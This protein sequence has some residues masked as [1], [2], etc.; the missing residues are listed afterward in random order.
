MR[1]KKKIRITI[2]SLC[3]WGFLASSITA[4]PVTPKPSADYQELQKDIE[5]LVQ[6][7][8]KGKESQQLE[9]LLAEKLAQMPPAL[10]E[11]V[12]TLINDLPESVKED[13]KIQLEAYFAGKRAPGK[14]KAGAPSLEEMEAHRA[15]QTNFGHLSPEVQAEIRKQINEL[16][17]KK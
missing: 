5:E 15:F 1:I 16:G 12:Q 8:Q 14:K 2:I 9:R 11:E 17:K 7:L 13:L 6:R 4:E 3:S 10:K